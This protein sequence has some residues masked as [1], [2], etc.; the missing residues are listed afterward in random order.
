MSGC[1]DKNPPQLSDLLKLKWVWRDNQNRNYLLTY[2]YKITF[3][4]H[5][6]PC[7][8]NTEANE[9]EQ[10]IDDSNTKVF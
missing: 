6:D 10:K 5:F 4:A 1:A 9:A 7:R 2:C 3:L 8:I